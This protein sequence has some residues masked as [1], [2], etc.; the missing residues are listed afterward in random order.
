MPCPCATRERSAFTLIELLI[1]IAVI[2]LIA[3]LLIPVI[4]R[5]HASALES[6]CLAHLNQQGKLIIREH[7]NKPFAN[8]FLLASVQSYHTNDVRPL[9]VSSAPAPADWPAPPPPPPPRPTPSPANS[10]SGSGQ[11][12]APLRCPL[13]VPNPLYALDPDAQSPTISYGF[14]TWNLERKWVHS[15]EWLAAD[16]NSPYIDSPEGVAF[17]RHPHGANVLFRDG[18]V[19]TLPRDGLQFPSL[20]SDP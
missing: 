17:D 11:A 10:P 3:A 9:T 8:D 16:S 13:A 6:R 12:R 5:S 15:W 4:S 14:L 18:S 20:A 7:M 1:V 19:T 2:A